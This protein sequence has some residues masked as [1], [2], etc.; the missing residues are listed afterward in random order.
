MWNP[1]CTFA[2]SIHSH[3]HARIFCKKCVHANYETPSHDSHSQTWQNGNGFSIFDLKMRTSVLDSLLL[4]KIWQFNQSN[5]KPLSKYAT[6]PGAILWKLKNFQ[7]WC[8]FYFIFFRLQMLLLFDANE[9]A[10]PCNG[11]T[12]RNKQQQPAKKLL[13]M[14]QNLSIYLFLTLRIRPVSWVVLTFEFCFKF[15]T[16]STYYS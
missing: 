11:C 12:S 8:R 2:W 5:P 7:V 9:C 10:V 4:L 13:S 15:S 16:L 3:T 1:R 6:W 14:S